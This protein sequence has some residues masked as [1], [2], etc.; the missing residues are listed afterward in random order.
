MHD[1]EKMMEEL[2]QQLDML[3]RQ[4]MQ[5]EQSKMKRKHHHQKFSQTQEPAVKIAR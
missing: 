5:L 2:T 3:C 4:I 1:E